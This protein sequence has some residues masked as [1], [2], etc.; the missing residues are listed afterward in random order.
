MPHATLLY[1]QQVHGINR[2]VSNSKEHWFPLAHCTCSQS[3]ELDEHELITV[4]FAP[5]ISSLFLTPKED[6]AHPL[7]HM[8][9]LCDCSEDPMEGG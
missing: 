4:C 5:S 3:S 9:R 6:Q 7:C 1:F 8:L 2:E